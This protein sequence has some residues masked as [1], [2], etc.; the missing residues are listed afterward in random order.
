MSEI[1]PD[2][3]LF[4]LGLVVIGWAIEAMVKWSKQRG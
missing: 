2:L 1:T 3:I 4:C